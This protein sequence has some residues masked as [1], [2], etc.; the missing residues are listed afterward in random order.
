M[1]THATHS[2]SEDRSQLRNHKEEQSLYIFTAL[3]IFGILVLNP[4]FL[5]F[6]YVAQAQI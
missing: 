2:H 5:T 4:L 1:E 6:T 3:I